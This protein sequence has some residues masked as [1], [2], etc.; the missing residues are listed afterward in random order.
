M[1]IKRNKNTLKIIFKV[2]ICKL[3]MPED[4]PETSLSSTYSEV[5][6]SRNP[7]CLFCGACLSKQFKGKDSISERQ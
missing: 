7:R 6:P 3:V 5:G 1:Q 4:S 2:D